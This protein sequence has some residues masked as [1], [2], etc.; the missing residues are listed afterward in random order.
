[1]KHD[2]TLEVQEFF[3]T[4][5]LGNTKPRISFTNIYI[6]PEKKQAHMSLKENDS[7]YLCVQAR[8]DNPP[9]KDRI[10]KQLTSSRLYLRKFKDSWAWFGHMP[11]YDPSECSAL[12]SLKLPSI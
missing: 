6:T 8:I 1:M 10:S 3:R 2:Q 11:S 12:Q 9:S 4:Y 7:F 5:Q